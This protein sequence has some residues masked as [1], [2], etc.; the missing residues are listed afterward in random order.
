[1]SKC[2][3]NEHRWESV[4][5]PNIPYR[6]TPVRCDRCGLDANATKDAMRLICEDRQHPRLRLLETNIVGLSQLITQSELEAMD[7]EL[8]ARVTAQEKDDLILRLVK[9]YADATHGFHVKKPDE[10]LIREAQDAIGVEIER[11]T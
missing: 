11:L 9:A 8:G 1:M 10:A 4:G 3:P 6:I 5:L 2:K 7:E